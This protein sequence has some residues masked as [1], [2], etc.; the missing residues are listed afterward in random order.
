M[1]ADLLAYHK[2]QIARAKA[3]EYYMAHKEQYAERQRKRR[4]DPEIRAREAY[5]TAMYFQEVTKK[6]RHNLE[7]LTPVRQALSK[8]ND[9]HKMALEYAIEKKP[10][11]PSEVTALEPRTLYFD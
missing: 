11:I 4:E 10:W 6:R 8:R 7:A 2:K 9:F 1:D 3:H 5:Y